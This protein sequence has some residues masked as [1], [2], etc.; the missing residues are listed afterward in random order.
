MK[1]TKSVRIAALSLVSFAIPV[2]GHCQTYAL[3]APITGAMTMSAQDLNGPTGSTGSFQLNFSTLTETIY[4]NP[5][6]QTIEQVGT[7][8]ATP[9]A[10]SLSFQEVQQIPGVFPNPPTSV[11]GNVTVALAPTGGGLS[12]DTGPQPV[13]WNASDGAYTFDGSVSGFNNLVGSYSLVTG[14]QTFSGSFTYQL[15]L[16]QSQFGPLT[17]SAF[18]AVSTTGYPNTLTLGGLGGGG[19][20]LG[21]FQSSPSVVANVTATNGF[22]MALSVGDR[23]SVNGAGESGWGV[24]EFLEWSSPGTVT[25]TEL[26]PE[27]T[28]LSLLAFGILGIIFLRRRLS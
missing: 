5:V 11:T 17:P 6:A 12:F 9:S 10:S 2:T 19:G 28:S 14:G 18:N 16:K 3:S 25:A 13:T 23:S 15:S 22:N 8:S 7:I 1:I 21:L 24:G 20:E 27:P 26:V 4:L